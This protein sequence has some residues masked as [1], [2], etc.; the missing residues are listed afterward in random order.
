MRFDK[1]ME[2]IE[3]QKQNAKKLNY[4]QLEMQK[5]EKN[6]IDKLNDTKEF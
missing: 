4:Q 2:F 5:E 3:M 1:E 6:Y